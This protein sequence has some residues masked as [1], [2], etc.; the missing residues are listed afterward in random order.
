MF[1]EIIVGLVVLGSVLLAVFA[2]K[3]F[4]MLLTMAYY[5][6]IGIY[7]ALVP[8][9]PKSVEDDVILITGGA[10][11]MGAIMGQRFGKLGAKIVL[12]DIQEKQLQ[13]TV[14]KLKNEGVQ[15][16]G[17]ICDVSDRNKIYEAA[18]KVKSEVG[19]VSILINN[20]GIMCGKPLLETSDETIEKTMQ[21]IDK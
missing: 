9:P 12:W 20:A 13:E 8:P 15:A 16:W 6:P 7:R 17:F 14:Q 21:V 2:P 11:G 1:I 10:M 3:H 4:K 5:Q 18:A 19:D